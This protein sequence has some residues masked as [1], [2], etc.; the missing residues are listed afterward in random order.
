MS[1]VRLDTLLAERGLFASR[2][3]AAASVMAGE[4]RLGDRRRARRQAR[5]AGR[6]GRRASRSTSARAS[7]R[8]A[9]S[10]SRTRSTRSGVDVAGP[11]LPGRR[12]LDRRLHRLPAAARRGARGRARRRLRRARLALRDD[13]ARD[14][15]RA[16]QRARARRPASCP[17]APDLDRRRRLVHL[18][19]KVLPAVLALLR[20]ERFDAWRWSSR[21]S[22]SAASGSARAASCATRRRGA[23]R[24]SRSRERRARAAPRCSASR[25]PACPGP[26]GNRETFVWLAEAGRARRAS[27]TSRRLP[28][29]VEP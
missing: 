27:P 21:S 1:K 17:Y 16:H 9:G 26:K 29:E 5:P 14:R 20:A 13:D 2:A 6:R 7:S 25:R 8:A 11:P 4:V 19:D 12:R 28:A 23:R 15:A 10:S 3:R 18:A 24:S 22:R